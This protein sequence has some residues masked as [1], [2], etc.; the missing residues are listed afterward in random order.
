M[1]EGLKT[2]EISIQ[3][4]RKLVT[5]FFS[6][7]R[8]FTSYAE[9]HDPLMVINTINEIFYI[10]VNIINKNFG[11]IDKFIGD[12]IMVEFPS[13]SLA[14]KSALEI[15]KK[16]SSYNKRRKDVLQVGI[17]INFGEAV[18]GAVGSGD[19]YDW[20]MIGNTV[21]IGRRLCGAADPDCIVVSAPVYEKL[22]TKRSCREIDI[23][24]KGISKKV[25]AYIFEPGKKS[26]SKAGV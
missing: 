6:D 17:G 11:D 14:F 9:E 23:K 1:V 21:N 24:V 19:K 25:T 13:P 3:P 8:G 18:V 2:G 15:Q 20:T 5:V 4:R 7:V 26:V 10:Q 16:I 12:E 22:K